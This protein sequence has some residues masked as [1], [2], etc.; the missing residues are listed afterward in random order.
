[1]PYNPSTK[2][3]WSEIE[4][5]IELTSQRTTHA[6][7]LVRRMTSRWYDS[8]I[9]AE[10]S[11]PENF[12]YAYV[13]NMLPTLGFQNP[14]VK[15]KAA[16]VIGHQQIAQAMTDGINAVVEDIDYGAVTERVHLDFMFSR[17]VLLH[18]IEEETRQGR[19]SVTPKVRRISPAKFF[20]DALA[21]SPEEAEFMGHYYYRDVEDLQNDPELTEEARAIIAPSEGDSP[22]QSKTEAFKK[23]DGSDVG[24]RRVRCYNVWIRSRNTLRVLCDVSKDVELYP[25][26]PF[27]GPDTGPYTLYDAYPVPDECWPL[28]PLIAVKDQNDDLNEH[29]RTMGEAAAR[30]KSIGLVE[31]NNP[32]LANKLQRAEDGEFLLVRGI[33]GNFVKAEVG[34]VT[35]EQYQFT[36]YIRNR[37]DRIS[38]LTATVQGN[39]GSADTAT[40]ASIADAHLSARVD[41]LK[42]KVVVATEKSLTKIGWYLFHTEGVIIPVNRRDAYTGELLEGMFF[43]GPFPTDAGATWHDFKLDVVINSMQKQVQSRDNMLQF[44]GIFYQIAQSAPMMPWIRVMN[45]LRDIEAVFEL[46]GKSEEWMIPELFGAFSQPEQLPASMLTGPG[47]PPPQ[48]GQGGASPGRPFAR[49]GLANG[50]A[51]APQAAQAFQSPQA[52][53]SINQL[54]Q[55]SGPRPQQQP[56]L[57]GAGG[58][59]R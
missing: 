29:A 17:G 21:S 34:G 9:K 26:R 36:E 23:P 28:S 48:P 44:F 2:D 57:A 49:L 41:Y 50:T 59:R 39:V 8:S 3:L 33:T 5:A 43:G 20:I 40:E 16:R 1:M 53:N 15:C 7:D 12:A 30:R 38:G 58:G 37:L 13:S 31:G 4:K 6:M 42:R 32:D 14:T 56:Q 45:V 46:E 47:Q 27:Y 18:R 54:G 25:E 24:R 52:G 35:K 19:G 22:L 10:E 55:A 11:D 51:G